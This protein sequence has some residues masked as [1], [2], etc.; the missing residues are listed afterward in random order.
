MVWDRLA[1]GLI[2]VRR[3]DLSRSRHSNFFLKDRMDLVDDGL[4]GVAK[5]IIDL[6]LQTSSVSHNH[7]LKELGGEEKLESM[8]LRALEE[9]VDNVVVADLVH[10]NLTHN[11]GNCVVDRVNL[12]TGCLGLGG[13]FC[14][15]GR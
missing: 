3:D 12:R 9:I 7:L 10:V 15:R 4:I 2:F 6:T 1:D 14:S 5:Q 8:L 11:A 13:L